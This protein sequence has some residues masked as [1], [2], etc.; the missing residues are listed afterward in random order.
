MKGKKNILLIN[1]AMT[2]RKKQI[3][4]VA[5]FFLTKI[6]RYSKYSRCKIQYAKKPSQHAMNYPCP[7]H[8]QQHYCTN[9]KTISGGATL[10][11]FP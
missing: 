8:T 5:H 3:R 2:L 9:I 6:S 7:S 4:G 1:L 10:F 11:A